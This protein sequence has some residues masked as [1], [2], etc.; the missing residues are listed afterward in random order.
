MNSE[1]NRVSSQDEAGDT[2]RARGMTGL[3][4]HSEVWGSGPEDK[5]KPAEV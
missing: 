1:N 2:G 5:H 4:S 3:W